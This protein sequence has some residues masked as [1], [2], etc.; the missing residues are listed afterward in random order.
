MCYKCG[1]N[2]YRASKCRSKVDITSTCMY[3]HR[4]GRTFDNCFIKRSNE[5]IEKQDVRFAK[6]SEPTKAKGEGP[7]GQNNIIFVKEDDS[8]KEENTVAAFKRSADGETLTEQ[9]RMKNDIDAYSK[10]QVKP[11]IAVRMN[12]DFPSTCKAPKKGERSGKK[13]AA[14]M[15]IAELGKKAEKYDLINNLTQ[16]QASNT[17]GHVVLN[18][19]QRILY[20]RR[21][22]KLHLL[23]M[24]L[25]AKRLIECFRLVLSHQLSRYGYHWPLLQRKRTDLYG[26]VFITE[27]IIPLCIQTAGHYLEWTKS[28]RKC[29]KAL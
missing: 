10:T 11:K 2:G 15:A 22:G 23:T 3:C 6:K 5:A 25:F 24:K 9:Q 29:E 14:K 4:I 16:A 18:W 20:T 12:H 17:F 26:S 1:K 8:M 19:H 13:V 21:Q 28:L 27:N 7:S